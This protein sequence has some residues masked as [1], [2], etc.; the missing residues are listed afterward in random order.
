MHGVLNLLKCSYKRCIDVEIKTNDR[1]TIDDMTRAGKFQIVIRWEGMA[2]FPG[3][4][5]F[6]GIY[7][8][9]SGFS[10]SVLM[11]MTTPD[12]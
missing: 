5:I 1:N 6:S 3:I 2:D 11:D 9:A 4:L 8:G 12:K 10:F 7:A